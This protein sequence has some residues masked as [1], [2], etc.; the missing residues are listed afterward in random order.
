[1]PH[2]LRLYATGHPTGTWAAEYL[3]HHGL[4]EEALFLFPYNVDNDWLSEKALS[5]IAESR[6]LRGR[7]GIPPGAPTVLGV[8]KFVPREDPM[9]LLSA[10]VRL[11]KMVPE[12][13]L[14]L[15]GDGELRGA[16]EDEIKNA[17]LREFVHLPGYLPYSQLPL[18][19]AMADIFVHPA[20][21]EQ[22]GVSVNEAMVCGVPV[23]AADT[24]GAAKDLIK[25]G[26]SGCTYAAGD[27]QA[28]ARQLYFLG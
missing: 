9:T 17:D 5:A 25:E 27:S 12:A 23:I 8:L 6:E 13:H 28:L 11:H 16:I 24:V 7:Y 18:H 26:E 2:V 1:M 4:P 21:R 3:Q 20:V 15:V 14:V 19:Y 10:F 22:W